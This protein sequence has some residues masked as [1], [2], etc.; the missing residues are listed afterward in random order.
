MEIDTPDCLK[1]MMQ[2]KAIRAAVSSLMEKHMESEFDNCLL[3]A[4]GQKEKLKQIFA[5]IAKK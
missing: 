4:G 3:H 5:E 2:L 1:I